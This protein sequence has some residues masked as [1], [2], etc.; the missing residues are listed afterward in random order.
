MNRN[1]LRLGLLASA[2]MVATAS[3][4]DD[5][6]ACLDASS[7]GQSLRDAHKLVEA[8]DQFRLCARQ[9]CPGIVQQDCGGWLADVE[10][11]VPSV[12][13]TAKDGAGA[14]LVDVRVSV[15][16]QPF[17]TKLDG[18]A[19]AINPGSHL[20]HFE[21]ADGTQLDRQVLVK[22]GEK[23]QGVAV[24]LSKKGGLT[25]TPTAGSPS[26]VPPTTGQ[27]SA[28][29]TSPSV[30]GGSAPAGG[31]SGLRTAGWV[32]GGAGVVGLGVGTVFG[33][34]A[35]GDKSSANCNANNQCEGGPLSSAKSAAIGADIGLIAG[36]VL[37][38]TGAS[39]V[40]LAPK[41]NPSHEATSARVE[42]A[43]RVAP[44]RGGIVLGGSW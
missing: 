34:M 29:P 2:M 7:K 30:A 40:L 28:E 24:V 5:K 44:G 17:A 14:D 33:I 1:P 39:L 16:G 38:A 8:R 21:L 12:V 23:N 41:A 37:L 43:P 26:T 19:V 13:V 15:D 22:E 42:I 11:G 4:A 32:L 27:P 9:Q 35:I 18:Q 25:G 3:Y 31:G 10:K 36:G 6:A 20:L